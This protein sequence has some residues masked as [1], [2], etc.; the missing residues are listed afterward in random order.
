VLRGVRM[1]DLPETEWLRVT[2]LL[3][4]YTIRAGAL[5]ETATLLIVT[6]G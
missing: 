4:T 2:L 6:V 1:L 5:E 3:S